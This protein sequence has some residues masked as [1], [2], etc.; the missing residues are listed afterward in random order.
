METG[1]MREEK[2]KRSDLKQDLRHLFA[3]GFGVQWRFCQHHW[4]LLWIDTQFL[5]ES[6]MPQLLH[7]VPGGDNAV[8]DRVFD[9]KTAPGFGLLAH[10]ATLLSYSNHHSIISWAT[11]N[12]REYLVSV[13]TA[14]SSLPHSAV[15]YQQTQL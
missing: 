14:T 5:V 2:T 11:N 4:I 8:F 9:R 7:V 13:G 3:I 10:V 12:A 15:H 6:V 1:G